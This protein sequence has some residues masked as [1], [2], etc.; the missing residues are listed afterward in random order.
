MIIAPPSVHPSGGQY[1]H[2]RGNFSDLAS[3][4][5][6]S[7]EKLLPFSMLNRVVEPTRPAKIPTAECLQKEMAY[8]SKGEK[9][10]PEQDVFAQ[11]FGE[12]GVDIK[13]GDN[14]Y[15]CPWHDG[16]GASLSIDAESCP[17]YCRECGEGGSLRRL[18]DLVGIKPLLV[19][20]ICGLIPT[21][22]DTGPAHKS[23]KTVDPLVEYRHGICGTGGALLAN[24]TK[25]KAIP[26]PCDRWDCPKCGPKFKNQAIQRLLQVS[27]GVFYASHWDGG[28]KWN[29]L[30]TAW[31]RAGIEYAQITTNNGVIVLTSEEVD[32]SHL[33][34][35]PAMFLAAIIPTTASKN[36][37]STSRGWKKPREKKEVQD[38]G[39][40]LLTISAFRPQEMVQI[41][42]DLGF[43]VIVEEIYPPEGM[44][45]WQEKLVEAIKKREHP[46]GTV[47]PKKDSPS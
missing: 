29:T 9:S 28:I 4:P 21:N 44:T 19:D 41:A 7:A 43:T 26:F 39:M 46:D 25:A 40:K 17:W 34:K 2:L 14:L 10:E 1:H 6:T 45:D 38:E 15:L 42:A 13:S 24:E 3:L 33:I 30:T 20:E 18:V 23:W 8:R 31:R 16:S 47:G 5:R 35:N 11:L 37:I 22:G 27:G 12:L 36:P 32:E